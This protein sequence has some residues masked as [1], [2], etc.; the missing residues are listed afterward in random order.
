MIPNYKITYDRD[1]HN[2]TLYDTSLKLELLL[3]VLDES[4][5]ASEARNE[6][7]DRCSV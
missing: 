6:D 4:K 3:N 7:E 1:G 5:S 2:V